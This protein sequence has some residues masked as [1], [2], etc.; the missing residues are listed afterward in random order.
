M[1]QFK[2]KLFLEVWKFLLKQRGYQTLLSGL[3]AP[4]DGRA[5]VRAAWKELCNNRPAEGLRNKTGIRDVLMERPDLFVFGE[6]KA[7]PCV[8]LSELGKDANPSKGLPE[9]KDENWTYSYEVT[10]TGGGGSSLL[11]PV[12]PEGQEPVMEDGVIMDDEE[13]GGAE[14]GGEAL[15]AEVGEAVQTAFKVGRLS[16]GA[17]TSLAA[18][19]TG[20]TQKPKPEPV[21]DPKNILPSMKWDFG[22]P[23][24][25]MRLNQYNDIVWTPQVA[26]EKMSVVKK[27]WSLCRALFRVIAAYGG[28]PVP[29]SQACSHYSV[30]ELKKD[31]VFKAMK[32]IEFCKLYPAIFNL[33]PDQGGGVGYMVYNQPDGEQNL[34]GDASLEDQSV[35]ELLS[36]LPPVINDPEY[37]RDKIQAL[38]IE[39]IHTLANRGSKLPLPEIGQDP[40]VQKAKGVVSQA[41]KIIEF[42]RAF[43]MNFLVTEV[44]QVQVELLS[45][46]VEDESPID[47]MVAKEHRGLTPRIAAR[48]AGQERKRAEMEANGEVPPNKGKGKGPKAGRP[49]AGNSPPRRSPPRGRGGRSRSRRGGRSRD[50]RDDRRDRSRDRRGGDRRG[51]SRSRSRR[52]GGGG[53][54]RLMTLE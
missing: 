36:S 30:Q 25:N 40:R 4:R 27:E 31:P 34:P 44:P 38:R 2:D 39:L 7:H 37:P 16:K 46:D 11:P 47:T 21:L 49:M 28:G 8:E 3:N 33:V 52:G 45:A 12:L 14:A 24:W 32:L 53:S 19:V 10:S 41:K 29:M 50:R 22:F 42:I 17:T 6:S 48:M 54:S 1:G 20:Q 9:F 15:D 26:D 13:G 23:G 18:L 5:G 51:R 43:P 35:N